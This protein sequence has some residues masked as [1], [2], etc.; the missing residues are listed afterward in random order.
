MT[1]TPVELLELWS[2][3]RSFAAALKQITWEPP[4]RKSNPHYWFSN[5]REGIDQHVVKTIRFSNI[6][7]TIVVKPLVLATLEKSPVE[8]LLKP[9]AGIRFAAWRLPSDGF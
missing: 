7:C 9:V 1:G 3:T 4:R 5:I 6:T 8:M 2:R